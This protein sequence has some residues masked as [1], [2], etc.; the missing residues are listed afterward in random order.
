MKYIIKFFAPGTT[1][2]VHSKMTAQQ[3]RENI[4]DFREGS[5]KYILVCDLFNEGIDIPETNLLVFIRFTGSR[6]VWMQQLGRGLRKTQNKDY[7]YVLDFV[8]SLERLNDINDLQKQIDNRLLDPENLITE[9]ETDENIIIHNSSLEVTY[10]QSAAQVLKLI[11]ELQYRLNSRSNA[12]NILKKFYQANNRIPDFEQLSNELSGIT[13]DQIAT[14]F[15]SYYGYLESTLP[16]LFSKEDFRNYYRSYIAKF[17]L[18][19]EIVPSYKAI[20]LSYQ[21]N[22]LLACTEKEVKDLIAIEFDSLM[23]IYKED[24]NKEGLKL[25][26]SL[27]LENKNLVEIEE[28]LLQKYMKKVITPEDLLNLSDSD[29]NEIKKIF[30]SDFF[31]LKALNKRREIN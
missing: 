17:Y 18:E 25:P 9:D 10:N 30:H 7:V 31:F 28:N 13:P 8:G 27:E 15:D 2:L 19:H 11:E 29:R 6:T 26:K 16:G 24:S 1:T 12:I 23:N 22:N 14:L 3:R 20:S 5:F 4:R 21:S